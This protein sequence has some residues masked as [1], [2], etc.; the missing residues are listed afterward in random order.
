MHVVGVV[1]STCVTLYSNEITYRG[2]SI[3]YLLACGFRIEVSN[4]GWCYSSMSTLGK[5]KKIVWTNALS[6]AFFKEFPPAGRGWCKSKHSS[7]KQVSSSF[8]RRRERG[9]EVF[10]ITSSYYMAEINAASWLVDCRSG[11]KSSCPL[12]QFILPAQEI[13]LARSWKTLYK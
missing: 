3:T 9:R 12:K 13:H 4:F 1:I 2:V 6:I 8:A 5:A 7:F 11:K 10:L